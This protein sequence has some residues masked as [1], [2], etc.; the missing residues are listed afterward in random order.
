VTEFATAPAIR[1]GGFRTTAVPE[2]TP[3]AEENAP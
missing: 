1:T 2:I 3:P